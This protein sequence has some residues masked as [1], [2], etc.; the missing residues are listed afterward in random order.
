M[1]GER[2][3]RG[4]PLGLGG[5][6]GPAGKEKG[7]EFD[8]VGQSRCSENARHARAGRTSGP[9]DGAYRHPV[10]V[11]VRDGLKSEP[12]LH[13]KRRASTRR[14]PSEAYLDRPA[15]LPTLRVA[16]VAMDMDIFVG[17]G[18]SLSGDGGT[19]CTRNERSV[20]C[21]WRFGDLFAFAIFTIFWSRVHIMTVY[22]LVRLY[23]NSN[24]QEFAD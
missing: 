19:P 18:Y 9:A 22:F 5:A 7:G 8:G 11:G 14:E 3:A 6:D 21:S 4:A 20:R 2:G 1:R 24:K 17:C 23:G 13:R 12:G 10:R 16:W 15:T